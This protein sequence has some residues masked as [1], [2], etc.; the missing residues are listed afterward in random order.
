MTLAERSRQASEAVPTGVVL[1]NDGDESLGD[2]LTSVILVAIAY[3]LAGRFGLSLALPPGYATAVWPPSGIALGTLLARGTRL[4]PGILVG[5]F[6]VNISTSFDDSSPEALALSITVA[7][8]LGGGAAVQAILGTWLIRRFGQFPNSLSSVREIFSLML[9]G[10]PVAC[11]IAATVGVTAL[12]LAGILKLSSVPFSWLTWWAGDSIGVFTFTP[13]VLVWL[14]KPA[15]DWRERRLAVSL[16][17]GITFALSVM[18]LFYASNWEK[19]R[20]RLTFN[21]QA[22]IYKAAVGDQIVRRF[23]AL[24]ALDSFYNSADNVGRREFES[25]VARYFQ[26]YPDV[27]GLSWN[28]RVKEEDR[29]SVEEQL[30]R[31]LGRDVIFTELDDQGRLVPAKHRSEYNIVRHVAPLERNLAAIGFDVASSPERALALNRAR[32]TGEP[33][34]TG[35][36]KLIQNQGTTPGFLVFF[37]VYARGLPM[38]RR[39]IAVKTWRASPP[40][41]SFPRSCLPTPSKGSISMASMSPYM[42]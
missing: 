22:E 3:Y 35:S 16:P 18:M 4:W 36:I 28:Q 11:L 34:A 10:G 32:I 7:I 38:R 2:W 42:T 23:D 17:L 13:L 37:P 27:V 24:R 20:L 12:T 9:L 30:R 39:P 31:E 41:C 26:L 19:D 21:N 25:F 8:V 33:V 5:S 15:E 29:E 6:F 1:R 40:A 14:V